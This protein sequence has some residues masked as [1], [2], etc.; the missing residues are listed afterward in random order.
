[1]QVRI[2]LATLFLMSC[3]SRVPTDTLSAS[4]GDKKNSQQV[5]A[6][7]ENVLLLSDWD[8]KRFHNTYYLRYR[9]LNG[10][11]SPIYP[12]AD[13]FT[14]ILEEWDGDRWAYVLGGLVCKS[15]GRPPSLG[16]G[17]E[18]PANL[19][20]EHPMILRR[21]RYRYR[22]EYRIAEYAKLDEEPPAVSVEFEIDG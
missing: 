1:M 21:G 18:I 14:G 12:T 19:Y 13:A 7:D 11:E 4:Q 15:G 22:V 3:H 9:L 16:P 10:S 2:L 6:Q 20:S 8:P 5:E 17:M